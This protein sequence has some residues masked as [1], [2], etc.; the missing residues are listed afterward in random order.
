MAEQPAGQVVV[1]YWDLFDRNRPRT[2][3]SPG[4]SAGTGC[5]KYFE[6]SWF[7]L[8]ETCSASAVC[9]IVAST[10]SSTTVSFGGT[11]SVSTH[12]HT[13][14]QSAMMA[15]SVTCTNRR[16]ASTVGVAHLDHLCHSWRSARTG[17]TH[18]CSGKVPA[19]QRGSAP[20]NP[21][22]ERSDRQSQF[23]RL[24]QGIF[25]DQQ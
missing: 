13:S 19:I 15:S 21:P 25:G 7:A 1:G 14:Q 22:L 20:E 12:I 18:S 5:H 10:S 24:L 4:S 6:Y 3:N 17:K 2:T 9:N 11:T 8:R 16:C 23:K